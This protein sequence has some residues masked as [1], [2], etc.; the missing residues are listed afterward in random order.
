MRGTSLM[1]VHS[2]ASALL[3]AIQCLADQQ[4]LRPEVTG[5]QAADLLW[6]LMSFDSFDLLYTGRSP[7]ADEVTTTLT[8]TAERSLC[9]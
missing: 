5:D 2:K 1:G 7:S 4:V 6:L 3:N 9:R 8:A